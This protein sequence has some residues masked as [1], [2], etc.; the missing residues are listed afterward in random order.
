MDATPRNGTCEIWQMWDSS[1]PRSEDPIHVHRTFPAQHAARQRNQTTTHVA[2]RFRRF[3][4][5]VHSLAFLELKCL[6]FNHI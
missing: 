1:Q 5:H 6:S 3:A 2:H 4:L